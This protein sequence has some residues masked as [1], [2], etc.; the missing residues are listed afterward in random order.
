MR[1][2]NIEY[3]STYYKLVNK[4]ERQIRDVTG[5]GKIAKTKQ[6]TIRSR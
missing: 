3:Y 1:S 5:K 4:K 2:I 6:L